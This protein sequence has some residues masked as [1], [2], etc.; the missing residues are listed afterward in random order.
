MQRGWRI[1]AL[2]P[3]CAALGI[4]LLLLVGCM[5][6]PNASST[7]G[8][9]AAPTAK[10][11]AELWV[12]NCARC[13]SLRSPETYSDAEWEVSMLHMRIRANL[14]ADEYRAILEF[15]EAGN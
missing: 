6:E 10:G 2:A 3:G 7:V 14:T 9:T 8:A 4:F 12:D 11:G 1:G 13:H 15:L 5:A